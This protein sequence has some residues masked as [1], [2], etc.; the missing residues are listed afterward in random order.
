MI[1]GRSGT[2]PR[3]RGLGVPWGRVWLPVATLWALE[4]WHAH[5]GFAGSRMA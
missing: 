1:A 5:P 2:S 4:S 3:E